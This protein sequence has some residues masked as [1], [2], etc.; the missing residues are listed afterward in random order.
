MNPQ[1]KKEDIPE[2]WAEEVADLINQLISRK[3]ENRLGKQGSKSIKSHPWFKDVEWDELE[4][5]RVAA[6]FLPMNVSK[7]YYNKLK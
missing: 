6:P 1:V 7:L 5:H 3:E 4:N 2:N